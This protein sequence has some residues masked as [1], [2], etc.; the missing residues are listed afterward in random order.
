M[1]YY[2]HLPNRGV[3][4][5]SGE[6]ARDFLQGLITRDARKINPKKAIFAVLLSPQGRFL[7]DFFIIEREGKFLLEM[8]KARLPDLVKRL[9]MYRL[10]SKVQFEQLP[11]Q[12]AAEWG[13]GA[14]GTYADPRLPELG[15]RIVFDASSR[16]KPGSQGLGY[17][18][19]AFAGTTEEGD[20]DRHRLLLGVPEGS[21]DLTFDRSLILEYGYDELGAVDFDKGCYVGQEVTARSKHRATLRKFIHMVRSEQPLP[22]KG[23]AVMA[24]ARE[25]GL[26]ASSSGGVGLAH[27]RVEE[28]E[29]AH[30]EG[31]PLSAN[32]IELVAKLPGWCKTAFAPDIV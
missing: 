27:L 26:M 23:T 7:Y 4:A 18:V 15:W 10:R 11:M 19:P 6:D 22:P 12:V 28:V 13:D 3:L 31:L 21:K 20:Y 32:G 8:E 17:E 14:E 29:R 16:R 30:R 25:A 1:M 24:G 5:V 9:T 2:S